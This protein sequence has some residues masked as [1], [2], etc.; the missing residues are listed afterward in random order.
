MTNLLKLQIW[1][2]ERREETEYLPRK[3]ERAGFSKALKP[4]RR[5]PSR[6][7]SVL[8]RLHNPSGGSQMQRESL[9][10]LAHLEMA[11]ETLNTL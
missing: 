5:G 10:R 6:A 3:E 2:C 7:N 9:V 4:R 1:K 8:G 11:S